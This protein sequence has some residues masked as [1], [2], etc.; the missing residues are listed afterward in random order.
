MNHGAP[1]NKERQKHKVCKSKSKK[2]PITFPPR[3]EHIVPQCEN[4]SKNEIFLL[5]SCANMNASAFTVSK[6]RLSIS[7]K[8]PDNQQRVM[9][10]RQKTKT[11]MISFSCHCYFHHMSR[12][13]SSRVSGGLWS[14][15]FLTQQGDV[16]AVTECARAVSFFLLT[17]LKCRTSQVG[18]TRSYVSI[19]STDALL[20]PQQLSCGQR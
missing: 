12:E 11:E 6:C 9:V 14:G 2:F 8:S 18:A 4:N 3:S 1:I 5:L 13:R 20:A 7:H 10:Y 15:C 19:K 16:T 17:S